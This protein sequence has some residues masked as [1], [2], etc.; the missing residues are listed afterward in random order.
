[1]LV[2]IFSLGAHFSTFG[3][4]GGIKFGKIDKK[5]LQMQ[6]YDKDTGA[7]AVVLADYGS[8]KFSY[9]QSAGFKL[10][11]ERHRR[12]KI[13]KKEG[14]DWA[15]F[16][17]QLYHDGNSNEETVVG[18]K[19][20][21]YNL[22][23]GKVEK[24]KLEKDDIFDEAYSEHIDLK[25]FT[26]PNVVE[27]S[28]I[29]YTYRI[30]SDFSFN[31]QDWEFQT[32]IPTIWSEY[33]V[34]I[35]EYYDYKT[36]QQGYLALTIA[37][38][39]TES[40]SLTI[41]SKQRGSGGSFNRAPTRTTFSQS[42][43]SYNEFVSRWAIED[44][45]A[46]IEES[47]ITNMDNYVSKIELE[48][49]SVKWPN[50]PTENIMDTWE[51]MNKKMMSSE[52]FGLQLGR[53]G[54]LKDAVAT[55]DTKYQQPLEKLN[56]AINHIKEKMSWN[57]KYSDFVSQNI[58]KA[59]ESGKGNSSEI[60]LTL[61]VLLREL[62][63]DAN[64]VILSTRSYAFINPAVPLLSKFN[65]AIVHVN[66]DGKEQLF[67]AI[68]RFTP[69]DQLPLND[70]NGRGRLISKNDTRWVNLQQNGHSK[71]YTKAIL[72]LDNQNQIT[73]NVT[74]SSS[75][76]GATRRRKSITKDGMEEYIK[77]QKAEMGDVDFDDFT[78]NNLEEISKPLDKV[79]SYSYE[80]TSGGN[81]VY[82]D[83]LLSYGMDENPLKL[84][85]RTYPVDIGYTIA[86]TYVMEL[87][88]PDGYIVDE[89]PKPA[90][91]QLPNKGGTFRFSCNSAGGRIVLSSNYSIKQRMF[92]PEEYLIIKEFF[93]L[94]VAK[95]AEKIVLKKNT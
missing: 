82:I 67:D 27:G 49:A 66:I 36:L 32:S 64:P 50:S 41:N 2:F 60:N 70:L 72:T 14:Y 6:T 28:V 34:A 4:S 1:M 21:T 47:F 65:H 86:D 56:A 58:R 55:I 38:N 57:E 68:D 92:L 95:H 18:L 63:F 91:V 15:E 78:I 24:H 74:E 51:T 48:L 53:K 35:P 62:G 61:I 84:E 40:K 7:V 42:S 10:V 44:V 26:M 81:V 17:I 5:Y 76:F 37:E 12:I 85:N 39:S 8:S 54:F 46:L 11:F 45:P 52:N 88:V 59:Y 23:N 33:T 83:P 20:N 93:N 9:V 25:K 22:V 16:K 19:G 80:T 13:L 75:G 79:M 29:E 73:A 43:L 3:Q 31:L 89:M 90:F 30:N 77:D 87:T 94:I 71:S 69:N